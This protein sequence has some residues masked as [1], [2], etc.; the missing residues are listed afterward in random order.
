MEVVGKITGINKF[1]GKLAKKYE[2]PTNSLGETRKK[3][4][5]RRTATTLAEEADK[6]AAIDKKYK[7]ETF[8]DWKKK[9]GNANKTADD[10]ESY[11]EKTMIERM[12]KTFGK[13][14]VN[15]QGNNK[16]ANGNPTTHLQD[17]MSKSIS[18]TTDPATGQVK[19]KFSE[20]DAGGVM[21]D[22]M[23]HDTTREKIKE[24]KTKFTTFRN[25]KA[26]A[27]IKAITEANKANRS[28]TSSKKNNEDKTKN[29]EET[30]KFLTK[31]ISDL[32]DESTVDTLISA[33]N[34]YTGGSS[35][36]KMRDLNKAIIKYNT[37]QG[38]GATA[39]QLADLE[40]KIRDAQEEYITHYKKQ[41]TALVK[42]ESDYK[43]H[44]ARLDSE[45]KNK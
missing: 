2:D 45:E 4:D 36:K 35:D 44:L 18:R 8:E 25:I 14:I 15:M 30:I 17:I 37:E 32:P 41:K 26:E 20:Y 7:I 34:P 3:A 11:V 24:K 12:N 16:D 9:K 6:Q 5:Q 40:D 13:D 1:A 39:A 28:K 43:N 23:K 31:K 19:I 27:R 21:E 42:A 10:Y 29:F 22:M 38:L 33:K